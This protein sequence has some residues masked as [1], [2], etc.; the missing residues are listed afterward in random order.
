MPNLETLRKMRDAGQLDGLID[1][2][3]EVRIRNTTKWGGI[4]DFNFLDEYGFYEFRP[5]PAPEPPKWRAWTTD[6][7]WAH[8]DCW[9]REKTAAQW[10]MRANSAGLGGITFG[11]RFCKAETMLEKFEHLDANGTWQPCGVMEGIRTCK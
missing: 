5:K 8:R 2:A 7:L 9:F 10:A 4:E 3:M 1:G 6:E 11:G